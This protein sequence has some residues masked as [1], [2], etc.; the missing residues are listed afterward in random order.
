[1][2]DY[3]PD[4]DPRTPGLLTV[5][6]DMVATAKGYVASYVATTHTAH[7]YSLQAGEI[8]P[9]KLFASRWVSSPGGI[10]LAST[11]KRINVYDY[12]NGFINVSKAGD[13]TLGAQTY[14]YGEDSSAAFD[15][16]AFGNII[17]AANKTQPTQY[18]SALDLTS[19]TLFADLGGTPK[20]NTCCA[21]RNF[22]FL[23]NCSGTFGSSTTAIGQGDMIA[24]S[25]I[26]DYTDW[27]L[28][29]Q[30]TQSSYAIFN[31]TPGD[32]TAIRPFRD[33]VVV[34]KAD[35]MYLGRYVGAGNNS[36]IWDFERVSDKVGCLGHRSVA[37]LDFALVFVSRDDIFLYDGTTPRPITR[38]IAESLRSSFGLIGGNG[39]NALRVGHN[40]GDSSVWFATSS[41]M[42][43]WNYKYDRWSTLSNPNANG[44]TEVM[45]QTNSDDF[46]V[47]TLSS[48]SGGVPSYATST[49]HYNLYTL[50]IQD[51]QPYNRNSSF[52]GGSFRMVTGFIGDP[53]KL[54]TLS[55][56]NPI[57]ARAPST[58]GN[59]TVKVYASRTPSSGTLKGSKALNSDYRA[60]NLAT[61]GATANFFQIEH[62]SSD[63]CEVVD[64]VPTL[65]PAGE[66]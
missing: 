23:A 42:N 9:N 50:T 61:A 44:R 51:G 21:A 58:V 27:S 41:L 26:G 48:V 15:F 22:V 39:N 3:R 24:W 6:S 63:Y 66:R 53:N 25:G 33:G 56:V 5:C 65:I 57:Y 8:Y 1:M 29:T 7:T 43:V 46:R 18:R 34:F 54:A 13:Y 11:N 36:P 40:K 64:L 16:C 55:R 20:A 49:N 10:V 35:S 14:Q 28:N 30:V 17:V 31:D 12:T 4:L 60:D 47:K 62:L 52:A 59:V 45:C 37:D 38:G 19:G 32:V 2:L